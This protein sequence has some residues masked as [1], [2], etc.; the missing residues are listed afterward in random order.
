MAKQ[1]VTRVGYNK[2]DLIKTAF[3]AMKQ[4]TQG[5]STKAPHLYEGLDSCEWDEFY[6]W[7]MADQDLDYLFDKWVESKYDINLT[8]SLDRKETTEGYNIDNV[9]WLAASQNKSRGSVNQ[10]IYKSG[11]QIKPMLAEKLENLEDVKYPVYASPK[12]DGIRCLVING[13]AVTRKLKPLPNKY[14]REQLEAKFK[15]LDVDG[16]IMIPGMD[17]N[18]IQSAVMCVKGEPQFDYIVFDLVDSE[19]SYEERRQELHDTHVAGKIDKVLLGILIGNQSYLLHEEQMYLS[20]GYE[21]VMLRSPEGKYKFGRS[22]VKQGYLLKLKRFDDSEAK[23]IG[24]EERMHNTNEAHE[25][26]LGHTERSHAKAGMVGVD[27][28]GSFIVYDPKLDKKFNIGTGK[29]LDDS[30]RK[31][32]WDN[33]GNYMGKLITYTYQELSKYGVPRFP[34][35]K[36]FRSELDV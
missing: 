26:A 11:V 35:F 5:K 10:K 6:D 31:L 2:A 3:Y 28:L 1:A 19:K 33:R 17:F 30:Y 32:I 18:A 20:M 21:G 36:G 23:V 8:P 13:K 15:D 24:F 14:I 7:A 9:R 25:D 22:T 12:L 27:T 29:G 34:S 16:E 4:R